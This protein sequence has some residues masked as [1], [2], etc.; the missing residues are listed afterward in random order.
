MR[1][2]ERRHPCRH[3]GVGPQ[4]CL[5]VVQGNSKTNEHGHTP[6]QQMRLNAILIDMKSK[7]F[8]E[9]SIF[10]YS[11]YRYRRNLAD[12]ARHLI[13]FAWWEQESSN[14]ELFTLGPAEGERGAAPD[15]CVSAIVEIDASSEVHELADALQAANAL[16]GAPDIDVLHIA[17]AVANSAD[18][19]MTWKVKTIASAH[20]RKKIAR[21]LDS[22]GYKRPEICTPEQLTQG[23]ELT[24]D[25]IIDE[26]RR[27]RAQIC[28]EFNNDIN[29]MAEYFRKKEQEHPERLVSLPPKRTRQRA[30]AQESPEGY[31]EG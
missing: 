28:Q 8:I 16:P 11:T 30:A 13:T 15:D 26:V 18:F 10:D 3:E 22:L 1:G 6:V 4:F 2:L 7:V 27:V 21:A 12:A 5:A 31:E 14:F 29:A 9:S 17:A 23:G 25:P 19:L 20:Y 24:S